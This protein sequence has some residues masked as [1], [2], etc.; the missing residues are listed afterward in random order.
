[1]ERVRQLVLATALGRTRLAAVVF[2]CVGMLGQLPQV[3][4]D[5]PAIRR[6]AGA[7]ALA[8]LLADFVLTYTRNGR[9][10]WIRCWSGRS[11]WLPASASGTRWPSS[12]CAS[13]P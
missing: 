1:M 11:W 3:S 4:P 7:I 8:L 12:G 13:A 9:P 10:G 2:A 5:Y 6:L